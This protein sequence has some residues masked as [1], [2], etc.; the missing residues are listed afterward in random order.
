MNKKSVAALLTCHNRRDKT[1]VCLNA[2]FNQEDFFEQY[3]LKVFLVDDGSTD[4]TSKAVAEK[5]PEVKIISGN[6][7][8]Y[9]NRGM[10]L[11][12]S[13][14]AKEHFD[15]YL[16]LN[17]DTMLFPGALKDMFNCA[18]M[19]N[20][21]AIIC[22]TTRSAISGEVTYGGRSKTKGLLK[23]NDHLQPCDYFNG[24]CVL[25]PDSVYKIVG[26]LDSIFSHSTGD[27]DYGLR[28]VK[29]DIKLLTSCFYIG[30]CEKH[31]SLPKWCSPTVKLK[32]RI[33]AFNTPLAV[34]PVQHFKFDLRHN[35]LFSAVKHYI[36][37]HIRLFFPSL[38]VHK[39]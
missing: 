20:E 1:V 6:G 5:F 35:G 12:W 27:W 36:T 14:A 39:P 4:G 25:V 37:I 17:D 28:A 10:H 21:K 38:W 30:T 31:D 7:N 24:N 8:L 18:S 22:G 13:E 9:W 16:W 11:A 15:F 23:P 3:N 34:N 29:A 2:L 19:T 33:K 32:E 26:N